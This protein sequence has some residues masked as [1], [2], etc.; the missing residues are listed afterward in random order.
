MGRL[1]SLII[2]VPVLVVACD[3]QGPRTPADLVVTPNMPQVPM[4]GTRQ[5]TATVVDADGRAIEGEAVTFESAEPDVVTVSDGGLLSSV[6]S[7]DTVT[8]TATSG[9]L[10]AEVQAQ[11]VP[12]PSSL[13][14]SPSSLRLAVGE[15]VQLYIIVT[16][17]HGD[18]IADAEFVLETDN[19]AVA[20]VSVEGRVVGRRS[21]LATVYVLS[22]E[23]RRDVI[24][25]VTP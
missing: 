15:V 24:V 20:S 22:G 17:E 5:L 4:G 10:A 12:P 23:H 11:V 18:S 16:D 8:I 19:L 21:G 7:L 6:G 2:L 14:V 13:V 1:R 25:A 3:D 9:D